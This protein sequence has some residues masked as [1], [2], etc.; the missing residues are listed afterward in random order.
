LTNILFERNYFLLFPCKKKT[1]YIFSFFLLT[2]Y[3]LLHTQH[4]KEEEEEKLS[5]RL[6]ELRASG[7]EEGQHFVGVN[8]SLTD[9]VADI[10]SKKEKFSFFLLLLFFKRKK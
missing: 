1:L 6:S 9:I 5:V 8:F 4:K 7:G 10:F 3:F 2:F